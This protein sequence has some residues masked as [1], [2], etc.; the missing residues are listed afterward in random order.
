MLLRHITL[1]EGFLNIPV[2]PGNGRRYPLQIWCGNTL[3]RE[4]SLGI[5]DDEDAPFFFLDFT[6]FAGKTLSLVLPDPGELTSKALERCRDG[7]DPRPG[8]PLY[9]DL[10]REALRPCFHF[11]SRRGWLNDPNGLVFSGGVFHMYYQHNPLGTPHGSVN[12]SWGHAVSKDLLHWSEKSDAILPWRRD[13]SIASGSALID[14]DNA[15]G[16]GKDAIICAFTTLGTLN[17]EGGNFP[18]GG[19]F[20]GASVDGG[21]TFYLFST[22]AVVPT[23]NGEGWR[24]PRLFRYKDHY[25]MAVYEVENGINCVSFYTSKD[26]HHWERVSRNMNLYECPDIFPLKTADGEEKWVLYGADGFCR[27][28]DF[29]GKVFHESGDKNPLDYGDATYAGQTWSDHP[30]GK[31][32]HISWIRGMGKNNDHGDELGYV[33][34]PFSQCMSI[35]C[36]LTLSKQNGAFRVLRKPAAEFDTLRKAGPEKTHEK[37][38]GTFC[39]TVKAPEEYVIKVSDLSQVFEIKAGDHLV[40]F[41][42]AEKILHFENGHSCQTGDG[43][44]IIRLLADTTTMELFFNDGIAC[45]YAMRPEEMGLQFKGKADVEIERFQIAPALIV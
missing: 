45:T 28:G 23:E 7:S 38:D 33:G 8:N 10:Y 25:C 35:P 4:F 43:A 17:N 30:E 42:P 14:R 21:D 41:D 29:D 22:H 1:E 26:F 12:V 3:L 5:T 24:D 20:L 9:P 39:L 19:Q 31:R 37:I 40:K 6:A 36:E 11:S 2:R 34:M 18:S 27:I 32:V 44:L 15:A 16:Y 13:W